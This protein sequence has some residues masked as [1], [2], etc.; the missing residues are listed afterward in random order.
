M[1]LSTAAV[2]LFFSFV[3]QNQ[4]GGSWHQARAKFESSQLMLSLEEGIATQWL[5]TLLVQQH[6]ERPSQAV[7]QDAALQFVQHSAILTTLALYRGLGDDA[8]LHEALKVEKELT[9]AAREAHAK[10]DT[11][12]LLELVSGM[13]ELNLR[14]APGLT[15]AAW[16]RYKS[17]EQREGLWAIVSFWC[18]VLGSLL[19]AAATVLLWLR[20]EAHDPAPPNKGMHPNGQKAAGG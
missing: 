4:L 16:K 18:T 6:A 8:Q 10:G 2:L 1:I 17:I 3:A 20:P 19:T 9:Q 12:R 14:F 7:I 13:Q 5:T 15:E 11:K